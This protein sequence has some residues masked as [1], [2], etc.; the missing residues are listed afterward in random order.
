[1]CSMCGISGAAT[2]R[3]VLHRPAAWLA[4][5]HIHFEQQQQGRFEVMRTLPFRINCGTTAVTVS[6]GIA[7]PTPAEVPVFV[8]MAVLT[9]MTLPLLS[10]RGPPEFPGLMAASV[11]MPPAMTPP[12]WLEMTRL[13][14]DTAPVVRVWS[15]PNG[16]LQSTEIV[17]RDSL[18]QS[19]CAFQCQHEVAWVP[20]VHGHCTH[21]M[22]NCYT[23]RTRPKNGC[24]TL[25]EFRINPHNGAHPIARHCC[26]TRT[27]SL[28]PSTT[29]FS[30]SGG[31]LILSTS[32]SLL[33]AWPASVARKSRLTP[34]PSSSVTRATCSHLTFC[35]LCPCAPHLRD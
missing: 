10:S 31:A 11:W 23:A 8:K 35:N 18:V 27:P 7:K 33:F 15:K 32:R 17:L 14:P 28:D 16:F 13:R 6:M 30:S 1:M 3:Q 34:S 24:Q 4:A 29:G 12:V 19:P 21:R 22:A 9:P 2:Q 20:P 5:L 26:P 25:C